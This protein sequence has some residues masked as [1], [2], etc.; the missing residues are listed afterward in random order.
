MQ[1]N[2][3]TIFSIKSFTLRSKGLGL[4]LATLLFS[5]FIFVCIKRNRLSSEIIITFAG[6][7]QI[8]ATVNLSRNQYLFLN[9]YLEYSSQKNTQLMLAPKVCFIH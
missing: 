1:S 2:K 4:V 7:Q 9:E 8:L 6:K 3:C 5:V